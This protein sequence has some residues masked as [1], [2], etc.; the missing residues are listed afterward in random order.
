MTQLTVMPSG[1]LSAALVGATL[2]VSASAVHV[3]DGVFDARAIGLLRPV[4]SASGL[5]HT[6]F[7][8]HAQSPR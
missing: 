4:A 2:V 7:D 3:Y 1:G 8:R 5:G 6:L